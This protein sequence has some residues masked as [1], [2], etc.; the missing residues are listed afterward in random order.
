MLRML[1]LTPN[2][3]NTMDPKLAKA[4][5]STRAFLFDPI[6][7]AGSRFAP[8]RASVLTELRPDLR[9][10]RG[11]VPE[12][13]AGVTVYQDSLIDALK[14]DRNQCTARIHDDARAALKTLSEQN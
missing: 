9:S 13:K 7:P 12:S 3:L 5:L 1:Q 8:F 6:F 4:I 10:K 11:T 2:P 14:I